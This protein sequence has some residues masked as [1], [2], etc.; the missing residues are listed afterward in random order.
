MI[1]AVSRPCCGATGKVATVSVSVT[2][3]V[4]KAEINVE[5]CTAT[6]GEDDWL[7]AVQMQGRGKSEAVARNNWGE[8]DK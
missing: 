6:R 8:P 2:S 5:C 4:G 7:A 1:V 3:R